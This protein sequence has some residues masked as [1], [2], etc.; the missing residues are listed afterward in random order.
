M[1]RLIGGLGGET[2]ENGGYLP[3]GILYHE[4]QD[5]KAIL[6]G[7]FLYAAFFTVVDSVAVGGVFAVVEDDFVFGQCRS[8]CGSVD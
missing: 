7:I 1:K 6:A 5:C 4:G 2:A 8:P 3:V